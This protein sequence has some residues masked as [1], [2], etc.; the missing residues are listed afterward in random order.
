[1]APHRMEGS[2][3]PARVWGHA[4]ALQNCRGWR[5]VEKCILV[6]CYISLFCTSIHSGPCP[7]TF[8]IDILHG[9]SL[10]SQHLPPCVYG[11]WISLSWDDKS[12]QVLC[13]RYTGLT[14]VTS[15]HTSETRSPTRIP[16]AY[17]KSMF[18]HLHTSHMRMDTLSHLRTSEDPWPQ[19]ALCHS[20]SQAIYIFSCSLSY[21]PATWHSGTCPI[22]YDG[23]AK[24]AK[25]ASE[26][27][28]CLLSQNFQRWESLCPSEIVKADDSKHPLRA[29]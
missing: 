16:L 21:F 12:S 29:V 4:F 8:R 25:Q 15:M 13:T 22:T 7:C 2:D 26:N 20:S 23:G 18:R 3:R 10:Q 1:M 28:S 17:V 6:I 5:P 11:I 24:M 9:M 27:N 19:Q 14:G